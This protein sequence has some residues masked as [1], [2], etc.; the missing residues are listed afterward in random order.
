MAFTNALVRR[1][2]IT[3]VIML[4]MPFVVA[5]LLDT[6]P[7]VASVLGGLSLAFL[8][9]TLWKALRSERPAVA[10]AAIAGRSCRGR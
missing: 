8:V 6:A 1:I 4:V 9:R 5:W 2:V 7:A 10:L 3:F